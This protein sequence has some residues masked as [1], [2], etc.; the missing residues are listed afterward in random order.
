MIKASC[1]IKN[2]NQ[3]YALNILTSIIREF[4][5]YERQIGVTLSNEF[6]QTVGSHF[7]DLTYSSLMVIRAPDFL[8]G[9]ETLAVDNQSGIRTKRL[10]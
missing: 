10:G 8:L 6:Q 5:D 9:E 7:L 1:D 4:P 2:T 3:A